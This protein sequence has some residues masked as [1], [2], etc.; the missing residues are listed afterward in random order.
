M[1]EYMLDD[2]GAIGAAIMAES[3]EEFLKVV[4]AN[5]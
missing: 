4:G 2:Q 5:G 1:P 3:D